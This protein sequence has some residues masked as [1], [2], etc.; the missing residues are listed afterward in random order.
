[1]KKKMPYEKSMRHKMAQEIKELKEKTIQKYGNMTGYQAV[2]KKGFGPSRIIWPTRKE[3]EA[4]IE[5]YLI[6]FRPTE[7]WVV[8]AVEIRGVSDN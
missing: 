8:M 4:Y 5:S 1:M 7:Q 3:A 6:H 2:G